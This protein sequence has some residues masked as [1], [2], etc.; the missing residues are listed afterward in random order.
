MNRNTKIWSGITAFGIAGIVVGACIGSDV[1]TVAPAVAVLLAGLCIELKQSIES[2]RRATDRQQHA[3]CIERSAESFRSPNDG[4]EHLP[5]FQM[6]GDT[7]IAPLSEADQR[8]S[9]PEKHAGRACGTDRHKQ[10]R[11]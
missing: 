9:G 5:G 2:K 7:P 6:H 1:L 3:Q 4:L 10:D 11:G 8:A